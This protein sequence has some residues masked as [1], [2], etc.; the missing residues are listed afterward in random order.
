[1]RASVAVVGLVV[2]LAGCQSDP[3]VDTGAPAASEAPASSAEAAA[4]PA[5]G[6]G[7]DC[8]DVPQVAAAL[9]AFPE[10]TKVRIIGSCTQAD[11]ETNLPAE[12][13]EKGKAICDAAGATAYANGLQAVTVTAKD[14][15]EI[16]AGVKGAPCIGG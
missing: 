8:K 16:G 4:S 13:N 3:T 5:A 10:V 6:G 15:S 7:S 9:T 11:V 14:G 1:M 12:S 2:V